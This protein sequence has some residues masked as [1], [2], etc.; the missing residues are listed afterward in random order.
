MAQPTAEAFFDRLMANHELR[1]YINQQA[2]RR[3]GG[4]RE[5]YQDL[6]QE[7]WCYLSISIDC[8]P[9]ENYKDIVDSVMLACYRLDKKERTEM[10]ATYSS[11]G[12]VEWSN[13]NPNARRV[14]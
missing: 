11:R 12:S 7:A 2:R 3:C 5:S 9:L 6:I 10:F 8:M 4:N 1:R 13:W 14:H